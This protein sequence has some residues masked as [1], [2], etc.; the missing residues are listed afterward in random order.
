MEE[1]QSEY[2]KNNCDNISLKVE[3]LLLQ[4]LNNELEDKNF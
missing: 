4:K 1:L 3:N 2:N